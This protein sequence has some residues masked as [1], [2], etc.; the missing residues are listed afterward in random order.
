MRWWLII[1]GILGIFVPVLAQNHLLIS[2][3]QVS[4]DTMEYIEVFNPNP[5]PLSLDNYYL[6]DYNTYYQLVENAFPSATGDFLVQFPAGTSIDSAGVLVIAVDG[7]V[8]SGP[9]D[10][11]LT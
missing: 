2:E 5:V 11:E 4:P 8:F 7:S 6:T 1:C 9:A 10:F 3:I